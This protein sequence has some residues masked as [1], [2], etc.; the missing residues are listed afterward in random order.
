ML[1]L[2]YFKELLEERKKQIEK[3]ILETN[4]ELE[5]LNNLEINDE[6]DFASLC[7]DNLIDNA[8]NEKQLEELKEIDEALAKIEN[9]T[10]GI[11]EMCGE[12]IRKLRLKVKPYAKYCIACR[13]IIEKEPKF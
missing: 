3:N 11:C 8:L 2:E 7:T 5:E 12:P 9:G 4:V 13:E 6:G 10:Y 1:E